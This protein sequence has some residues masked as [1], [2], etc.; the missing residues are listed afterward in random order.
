MS[1]NTT[2]TTINGCLYVFL[3]SN[4]IFPFQFLLYKAETQNCFSKKIKQKKA[5]LMTSNKITFEL[6]A[7]IPLSLVNTT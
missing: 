7:I 6:C 2:V 3:R 5:V 1:I 4:Q